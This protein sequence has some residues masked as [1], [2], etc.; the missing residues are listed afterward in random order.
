MTNLIVGLTLG[1]VAGLGVGLAMGRGRKNSGHPGV[2][3][4]TTGGASTPLLDSMLGIDSPV[5]RTAA[6]LPGNRAADLRQNLRVKMLYDEEALNRAISLERE[7]SPQSSEEDLI[8]TAIERWE[9]QN[10]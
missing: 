7:R 6:P 9:R 3:A 8:Q 4:G 10:R 1:F 2:H 5:A